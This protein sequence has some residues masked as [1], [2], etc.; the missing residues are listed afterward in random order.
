M[1]KNGQQDNTNM[2]RCTQEISYLQCIKSDKHLPRSPFT[3]Q[4]F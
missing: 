1:E 2:T 3:G 4:F